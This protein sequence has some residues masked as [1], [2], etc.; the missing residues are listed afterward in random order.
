[1][2]QMGFNQTSLQIEETQA[3]DGIQ[4]PKGWT[5]LAVRFWN[6]YMLLP[7][8]GFFLPYSFVSSVNDF[9]KVGKV[10]ADDGS[11]CIGLCITFFRKD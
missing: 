9:I 2:K 6:L 4:L 3:N 10:R 11:Q 5:N 8:D 1:M 7:V